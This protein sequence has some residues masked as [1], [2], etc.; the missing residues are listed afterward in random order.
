MKGICGNIKALVLMVL[1]CMLFFYDIKAQ[2]T[3]VTPHKKR[4]T[5]GVVLCG[6]GAKGFSEIRVLKAL[7]DAGVP[8]DYIGGTSIGSIMGSLYAVGYDPDMMEEIVRAQDWNTMIY[9][10][11]PKSMMPIEMKSRK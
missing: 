4:P 1:I 3:V 2:D 5:V 8:V 9:D 11:I 6:G 7:D 10:K